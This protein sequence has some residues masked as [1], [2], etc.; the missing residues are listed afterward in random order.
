MF[1]HGGDEVR[2]V[3]WSDVNGDEQPGLHLCRGQS[4]LLLVND[5]GAFT[6]QTKALGVSAGSRSAAWA[7]YN[8]DD[9]PD[10]LT[11]NFQLFTNTGG[12]LRDDSKLIPAPKQRNPEGAGWIDYN[13][14]GLLDILI[15]NGEHGIC[16][17]ENTGKGPNWFR[18]V[19]AQAGLG[20]KGIGTGNGDFIVFADFVGD[21]YTDFF[22]NL[23]EGIL[24]H[25]EGSKSRLKRDTGTGIRLPGGSAH[26]R[27]LA[28]ADRNNN[29][30]TFGN[31]IDASG[32]LAKSTAPSFG[33]AWADVNID[34]FLDL[35]V[36]HTQGTSRLYLGN[37]NGNGKF[38]DVTNEAGL[39]ELTPAYGASFADIDDDGDLDLAVN[40]EG[41]VVL[42]T[43]NM[44]RKSDHGPL[45][46]NVQTRKGLVGSVLRVFDQKGRPLGM[47]ELNGAESCGGQTSPIGHFGLPAGPCRVSVC[48]SDGRVAQKT[49]T[50]KPSGTS[51][52]L[53]EQDFK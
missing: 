11:N 44:P 49:I 41:R 38:Q 5:P 15:T 36:C 37:G 48:M 6:D 10:L 4:N 14:D 22:Y 26:K 39:G 51:L 28:F 53:R 23:G 17:Y 43:N 31:V 52:A 1:K 30:G 9:H 8:G 13:G 12:K 50:I 27:G 19:S 16:L 18:D 47:R 35:F 21:G 7:D 46:V 2:G 34:G 20:P 45:T 3:S 24:A 32:D 40:L 25:N 42:A 29:D 33:C